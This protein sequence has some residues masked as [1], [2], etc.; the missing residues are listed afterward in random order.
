MRANL[1]LCNDD[2]HL[3]KIIVRIYFV[4]VGIINFRWQREKFP[5]VSVNSR[6]PMEP[7]SNLAMK[8]TARNTTLKCS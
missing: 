1:M 5:S 2:I 8:N 4:S 3:K 7:Y 6:V